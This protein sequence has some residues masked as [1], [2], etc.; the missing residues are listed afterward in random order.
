MNN[1]VGVES[2]YRT[3]LDNC[4]R[5]LKDTFDHRE[6]ALHSLSH[7]FIHDYG[8][9]IECL[10]LRPESILFKQAIGQYQ[11][12]LLALTL[13][14]YRQ[15]F[16][17]MR[18]FLEL[19][20]GGIYFSAH[21]FTLREW[22]RD[23][24]DIKW[25]ILKD[26]N[27]GV[28]SKRFARAFFEEFEQYVPQ[29]CEIANR[30]YRACSEYIHGNAYTYDILASQVSFNETL[31][32]DWHNKAKDLRFLMLFMFSLRYLKDL[33]TPSK[34]KVESILVDELGHI[35]PIRDIFNR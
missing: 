20:L 18:L 7:S 6:S 28:F 10:E 31:F 21:E 13:G 8:I 5:V 14:L 25:S 27:T 2:Y 3:L 33:D 32:V 16:S 12:S 22:L 24:D 11:F 1:S 26:E 15:A 29:Y 30:V 23:D 34:A 4:T 19:S 17:S 35:P 9:W